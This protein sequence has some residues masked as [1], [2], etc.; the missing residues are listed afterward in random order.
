VRLERLGQLQKSNYLIGNRTHDL[1]KHRPN[2]HIKLQTTVLEFCLL[3]HN[4]VVTLLQLVQL[5]EK[6]FGA[7]FGVEVHAKEET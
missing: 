1:L 3:G 4:V 6:Y 7:I 5:S 2:D